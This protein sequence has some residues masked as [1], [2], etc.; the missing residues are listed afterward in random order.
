MITVA[1]HSYIRVSVNDVCK[2]G[3]LW[4]GWPGG[5]GGWV[6]D[7]HFL[8]RHSPKQNI[9]IFCNKNLIPAGF[10]KV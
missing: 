8:F 7:E 4:R 9:S 10:W 3:L 6:R 2:K 5:G 1:L